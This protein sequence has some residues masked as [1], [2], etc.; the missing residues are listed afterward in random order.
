METELPDDIVDELQ[1]ITNT[2]DRRA[3][4][5]NQLGH[6]KEKFH[7]SNTLTVDGHKFNLT[8]DFVSY[9]LLQFMVSQASGGDAPIVVLDSNEL[10]V[11]IPSILDFVDDVQERHTEALNEYAD[12]YKRLIDA[13]NNQELLEV[14]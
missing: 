1:R 10:P 13:K 2:A 9:V 5:L 12:L 7:I 8:T 3:L 4:Y 11:V 6:F 14:K